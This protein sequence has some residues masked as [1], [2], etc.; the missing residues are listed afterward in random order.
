MLFGTE[1]QK[2]FALISHQHSQLSDQKPKLIHAEYKDFKADA[3]GT[4]IIPKACKKHGIILLFHSDIILN[5]T[6][7]F[8]SSCLVAATP[9]PLQQLKTI[10]LTLCV[11]LVLSS[12]MLTGTHGYSYTV[13]SST[14]Q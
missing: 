5:S 4:K 12:E 6:N 3:K 10:L 1:F 14:C 2:L 8:T 9:F 13:F 11:C 7:R